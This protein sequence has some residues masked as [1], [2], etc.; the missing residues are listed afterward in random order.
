MRSILIVL[1][2]G[3]AVNAQ[4]AQ[5]TAPPATVVPPI[6]LPLP[7]LMPLVAGGLTPGFPLTPVDPTRPASDL[8]RLR[9]GEPFRTHPQFALVTGGYVVGPYLTVPEPPVRA[10]RQRAPVI[11]MLRF[12]VTPLAAQV[13]VDSY[14]AGT[15]AD[16]DAQR[17][18]TLA[19]GPH[20]IEI[21]ARE[22]EPAAFDV[23]LEPN[24]TVTYRAALELLRPAAP[25]RPATATGPTR[26]YV[27][28][29]CYAG[30]VPPRAERLPRGC[31]I[32]HVRILG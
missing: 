9:P 12:V 17:V 23:R 1:A 20:R 28:P 15:I 25:L 7:P 22:Y 24:E 4:Q 29:N 14:Y 3:A 26:M 11:G 30:N 2:F 10:T 32:T 31:D 8:F 21:R 5:S 27:I 6:V 13:F 16:I 18:L 19:A